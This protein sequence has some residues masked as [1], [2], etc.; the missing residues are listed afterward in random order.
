MNNTYST[1]IT[2]EQDE[3]DKADWPSYG[4]I[5]DAK[6]TESPERSEDLFHIVRRDST[7]LVWY[8]MS[9]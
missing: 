9:R 6:H 7:K 4:Q 8:S 2:K 5:T 3:S 1:E